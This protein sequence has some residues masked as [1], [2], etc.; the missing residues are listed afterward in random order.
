MVMHKHFQTKTQI[1]PITSLLTEN[2]PRIWEQSPPSQSWATC[3]SQSPGSLGCYIGDGPG[4]SV[5]HTP[6]VMSPCLWGNCN[7]PVAPSLPSPGGRIWC[8]PSGGRGLMRS[9]RT[10]GTVGWRSYWGSGRMLQ[11]AQWGT[12]SDPLCRLAGGCPL[13]SGWSLCGTAQRIC[14]MEVQM[15]YPAKLN[16]WYMSIAYNLYI[17][18]PLIYDLNVWSCNFCNKVRLKERLS[19]NADS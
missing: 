10:G 4:C 2:L 14:N 7:C 9:T 19:L 12:W 13:G 6:R 3:C 8:C 17:H 11:G 5:G 18:K 16:L 15:W 1:Q